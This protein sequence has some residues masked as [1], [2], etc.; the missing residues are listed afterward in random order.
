[1][2]EKSVGKNYLYN[3]AYQLLIVA[4]PLIT[5]PYVS[6][7]LTSK[8]VGAFSYTTSMVSYFTLLGNLGVA[9]YGQLRTAVNRD[10]KESLTAIFFELNGL[11]F[12]LMSVV[13][14]FYF[15]FVFC[16][17]KEDNRALYYVL[18]L[19]ILSSLF[20]ISWFMQGLEEFK[21]LLIR[22]ALIKISSTILIFTFVK[23]PSDLIIYALIMNGSNFL[24]NISIWFFLPRYIGWPIVKSLHQF[25][26]LGPCLRYFIP[27]IATAIYLTIDKTMIGWFAPDSI[28]NGLYEQAH[29][30]EFMAVTVVTS[31]SVVAMPRMAFLFQNKNVAMINEY[32][33]KTIRFI[34]M[35]SIPMCFGAAAV[36]DS[37]IPLYLGDGYEKSI[38]LFRIFSILIVVVGL[39][40]AVGKQVLIASGKQ[41][42]YNRAVIAGAIIN[43]LLNLVLIPRF[44]SIG[45]A[46]TSVLSEIVILIMFMIDAQDFIKWKWLIMSSIKYFF[47]G[48]SLFV[49]VR[50]G[51]LLFGSGWIGLF[52]Q[53]IIG[54]ITYFA[55]LLIVKDRFLIDGIR[56]I[57]FHSNIE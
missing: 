20:D 31:L 4:I 57:V 29:K 21:K 16:F 27:T 23:K 15:V 37:F 54:V 1:M 48:L 3:L 2:S 56:K 11:R 10:D 19:Q 13:T 41:K 50:L 52:I 5:T 24:G 36:A 47:G 40:N 46:F 45:A 33:E 25:R 6:R 12:L 7:V 55:M 34:L 22:N 17:S 18:I 9:T 14:V 49:A 42:E 43:V 35:I 30:V 51:R 28:E 53:I 32:L 38:I 44:Y 8:G 39:N 26:H